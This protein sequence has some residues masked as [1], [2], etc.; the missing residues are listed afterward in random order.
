MSA[1]TS[2]T[3]PA[4][5]ASTTDSKSR[6]NDVSARSPWD[7][8]GAYALISIAANV[9]ADGQFDL[10]KLR[11]PHGQGGKEWSGKWSDGHPIWEAN[12]DVAAICKPA[13]AERANEH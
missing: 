1:D 9:G 12:P 10:L 7:E 11:N 5:A 6:R 2:R 4:G 3:A 8:S 13:H